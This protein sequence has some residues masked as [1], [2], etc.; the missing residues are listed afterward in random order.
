MRIDAYESWERPLYVAKFLDMDRILSYLWIRIFISVRILRY[1]SYDMDPGL[2]IRR[3][4]EIASSFHM[5]QPS[6]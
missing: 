5:Q 1:V 2:A 4:E 3:I 6:A